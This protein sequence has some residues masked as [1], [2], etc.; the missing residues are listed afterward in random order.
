LD[1]VAED[2]TFLTELSQGFF[3]LAPPNRDGLRDALVQPAEMAGYQFESAEMVE[4]MLSHLEST[5]GALPLLQFAASKLWEARDS[6]RH[7]LTQNSYQSMGGIAGA[8]ASHADAV[9]NELSQ[10]AQALVKA[11]FLRLITAE[12]TRAIVPVSEL[13]ELTSN[14]TDIQR[15]VDHLVNARLLVVQSGDDADGA[16]VEIVHESLIH[17][18]PLLRMWLD[19]NQDDAAF[20]EQLRNAA[21]QWQA[22]G[23]DNGLLWRGEAM[24]EAKRWAKRYRGDLPELQK[25]Y[26][27]AVFALDRRSTQVRR[28]ALGGVIAFLTLCVAAA[29]IA[30][31][32][33]RDA[34][35]QANLQAA[36][37]IKAEQSA[38]ANAQEAMVQLERVKAKEKER[39]AAVQE[40]QAAMQRAQEAA[41]KANQ[42]SQALASAND[43]L[44]G[45]LRKAKKARRRA[46]REANRAEDNADK[47]LQAQRNAVAANDK[48][49][50]ALKREQERVRRLMGQL[51]SG[52]VEELK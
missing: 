52:I 1:R 19:E 32:I 35:E 48:L 34:N 36:A 5:P 15:L 30:L 13:Y 50:D 33:I 4:D 41:D 46:K 10:P 45:A 17:S 20:L 44:V 29:V 43:D 26:L 37:A 42:A 18:W 27:K 25:A 7:L 39:L 8:L 12:R 23:Y 21:K 16:A 49:Q 14:P 28:F 6:A 47:A 24:E 51:G 3:F 40:A 2:P 9:L 31:V 38:K 11:I 22:K